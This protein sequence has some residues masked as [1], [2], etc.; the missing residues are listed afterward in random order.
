MIYSLNKKFWYK[1]KVFVTGHTGFKG[2]WLSIFL[3][4][5]GAEVTGYSLKPKT[6]PNL[7]NLAQINKVIKKS[8]I[9][10]I[11]DYNKL[12]SEIKKSRASIVFHLAAQPLVRYSYINPKETFDT[13]FVGSLN[14]L[15]CVRRLKNI[16]STII[17]TTDKVYD[18]SRNKVFKETDKLGGHDPYSSSKVCVESLFSSYINSFFKN[19][20]ML[21]TVRAGNVIGGGDYSE[22]RLIPDVY[23]FSKKKKKIILRNP[24]SVR[25][26]QHVLDPLGGYLLL[27]EK[28]HNKNIKKL[29]QNWNFGPN[30]LSCKSVKY[31]ASYFANSLKLK[32]ITHNIKNNQF[33]PETSILRLSNF[34]AKKFL[35]WHPKWGL[36]KSLKKILE[37]NKQ[38]KSNNCLEICKNQ[39]KEFLYE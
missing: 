14:I 34:K 15:E 24:L 39:I 23:R 4:Y 11:R 3:N 13:N 33:K 31:V 32:V 38:I 25:P 17:I 16:K 28:L 5:L 9:A 19:N 8:I 6:R 36:N 20:Q 12:F 2:S 21:A 30:L 18:N 7:Y 37:W 10:D 22:D 35:K 1:K 26:W 29:V 27:T